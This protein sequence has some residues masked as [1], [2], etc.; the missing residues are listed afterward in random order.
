MKIKLDENGYVGEF[1]LVGDLECDGVCY[2]VEAPSD[3]DFL[4]KFRSYKYENGQLIHD[5]Y[6]YEVVVHE[7]LV[8]ELRRR[9]SEE[10]FPVINRGILWYN[11]LTEDQVTELGKWY[12]DWL[13]VTDTLVIPTM[14]EWIK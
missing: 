8:D 11:T 9:R 4:S 13:D 12:Q 2:E 7:Q 5:E 1:A 6:Q 3:D 14:P 10:C